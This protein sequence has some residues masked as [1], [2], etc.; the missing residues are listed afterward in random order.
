MNKIALITGA[1]SGIG[2]AT[3]M[4]LGKE[5]YNLIITGRRMERLQE[6]KEQLQIHCGRT[7]TLSLCF[8]V[9]DRQAV[10]NVLNAVPQEWQKIDVLVNNAGLAVGLNPI[11]E[12]LTD[13]W[14]RMIDTN[15]KG[16]LYVTRVVA[17]WMVARKAGHIINICSV[18]G[19]EVYENG[20]VYCA[21]KHAVDAL[22]KAMRTDMLKYG[23]KVTNVCPGAVETEF[24]LVR[25]KDDAVRAAQTYSGM[26]PLTGEDVAEVIR[27]AVSLPEHVCINDL[28]I[29]PVAQAN[30]STIFRKI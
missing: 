4:A 16:L 25:F 15:I 10:E 3:A 18:A 1:T 26:T 9:R 17:P 6:L 22:S 23:I 11:Q 30:A 19:K 28:V 14:E 13:D 24:S 20:N 27:F 5:G 21:T 12:G 8:D 2:R 29:T 7:E